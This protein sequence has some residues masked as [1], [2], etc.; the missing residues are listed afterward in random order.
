MR[1]GLEEIVHV[2]T[3][4]TAWVTECFAPYRVV[5]ARAQLCDSTHALQRMVICASDRWA[6][7]P[8][9]EWPADQEQQ[10]TILADFDTNTEWGDRRHVL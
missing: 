10:A 9:D 5:D 7:V 6:A 2:C 1:S 4:C 3:C 8:D